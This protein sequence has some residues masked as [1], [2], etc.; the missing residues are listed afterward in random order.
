MGRGRLP[1]GKRAMS[2]AE[3]A[4][5][6]RR[7]HA[8]RIAATAALQAKLL[9]ALDRALAADGAAQRALLD[10]VRVIRNAMRKAE[11]RRT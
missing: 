1:I 3:R 8:K 9:H 6:F 7:K 4:R 5:R 11:T 10:K 2:G